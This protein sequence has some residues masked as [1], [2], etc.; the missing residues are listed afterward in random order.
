MS[1]DHENTDDIDVSGHLTY[2]LFGGV[3]LLMIALIL[4][5]AMAS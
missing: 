2:G 5:I 3:L 1:I 4:M